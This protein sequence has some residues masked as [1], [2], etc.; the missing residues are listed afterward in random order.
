MMLEFK[1]QSKNWSCEMNNLELIIHEERLYSV[2]GHD[3]WKVKQQVDF[4]R[5]Y[6][7]S[8]LD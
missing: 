6:Y 1:M 2:S 5:L 4:C 7:S 8:F 3:M